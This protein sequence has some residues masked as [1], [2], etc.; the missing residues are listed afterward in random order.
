M[1]DNQLNRSLQSIG[2]KCFVDYYD[3]FCD[4]KLSNIDLIELLM[5]NERYK[6]SG[7]K[8]RVSQSR[9]II[10]AGMSVVAL[11]K[12]LKSSRLKD[13]TLKKA[14]ILLDYL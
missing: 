8:T 3:K 10:K 1:N 11:K 12:I 13:L 9:R 4:N 7:C 6:E 5:K 14:Q 2:M